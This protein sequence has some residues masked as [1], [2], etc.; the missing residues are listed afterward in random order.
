MTS[1]L[2]TLIL[3]RLRDI[4]AGC[5][6][7]EAIYWTVIEAIGNQ[8]VKPGQK[9]PT[10]AEWT[11]Q[12]P[13]SLGT[14]QRA[15]RSLMLEGWVRRKRGHGTYVVGLHQVLENPL[16]CRFLGRDGFLPVYATLISKT[17]C[18]SEGPWSAVLQQKGSNVLRIDRKISIDHAFSVLSRIYVNVDRFTYLATCSDDTLANSNIKI[19]LKKHHGVELVRIEQA[20]QMVPFPSIARKV[21][22]LATNDIGTRLDLMAIQPNAEVALYQEL[23]IPPNP[24]RLVVSDQFSPQEHWALAAT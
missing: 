5:P 18:L 11:E 19:L 22:G 6:K 3:K 8:T 13:V 1:K 16:H 23:Y 12:L 15:V 4:P 9:L 14:L 2:T 20:L 17:P 24:Y 7:H 10:E 21:T